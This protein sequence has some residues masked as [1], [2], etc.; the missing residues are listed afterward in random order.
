MRRAAKWIGIVVLV[1]LGLPVLAVAAALGLAN[2]DYG[3][4]LIERETASLTGGMVR[5]E[6][7]AGRF[8]DALRIGRIDVAD[9]KGV[10][11][12]V[13]GLALDWSPLKLLNSVVSV[14]QLAAKTIT[15]SRLPVSESKTTSSSGSFSLPVRIDLAKLEVDKA[16]IEAPVVGTRAELALNGSGQLRTLTEGTVHLDVKRLDQPGTYR[17]D[18]DVTSAGVTASVTAQEPP[19][20]LIATIGQLPDLGAVSIRADVKGPMD[21]LG[22]KVAISAGPLTADASGT[23]DTVHQAANLTLHAQAPAMQ[24][25]PDIGWQRVLVDAHV[26]G[27]FTR[28]DATGTIR[29]DA[30]SAPGTTIGAL[31][32]DVKGN[33]GHVELHATINDLHV[34]GPKPDLLSASPVVVD[35]AV[36]LDTPDRPATFHVAHK[37]IDLVG[38]AKLGTAQSVQA[39]LTLPDLAPLAQA[40][41]AD[42][43]GHAAL[44]LAATHDGDTSTASVKGIVAISGGMAPVPALIGDNGTIDLAAKMHGQDITLS[45]LAVTGKSVALGAKGTVT[46]QA[47]N[48]D[49]SASLKDLAAVQP[50]LAGSVDATGHAQGS[51]SDLAVH[52]DVTTNVTAQGYHSGQVVAHI[53]ATGLPSA[54]KAQVTAD[55]T[56]LDSPLSVALTAERAADGTLHADLSNLSWKSLQG[57]GTAAMAP[58]AKLPTGDLHLTFARLADLEPLL[59]RK[60]TGAADVKLNAD[61]QAA[62]LALRLSDVAVPGTA[63][64]QKLALDGTVTGLA[65]SPVIDATMTADGISASSV[66]GA[67]AQVTAK[68]PLTAI[69]TAITAQAPDVAGGPV[70]LA[71]NATVDAQNQA[72]A[73]AKLDA[74]WKDQ[75]L[76]LL[77][78]ARIAFADGVS[79]DRLRLGFR[80]A[81]LMVSGK[82]GSTLDLTASLRNLPAD[83]G[84]IVDPSLAADGTI[85]ADVRLTGTSSRPEGTVKL[86]AHRV[87]MRQGTGQ[88]L[89]P[90]NLDAN[91]TLQGTSALVDTR[92]TA[93]QT[94]VTVTG[95]APLSATGPLNLRT[96]AR[97]DL[98]MLD[99]ILTAEGRRARGVVTVNATVTGTATAPRA[100][101]TV[102]LRNGDVVDYTLGAHVS[103]LTA[104]IEADGD[105]IRLS[106]FS[107]KAGPGTLGG[108]GTISLA[109]AMPVDLHFT[110]NNARPLAS[111][112]LTALINA[113]LT[114]R[115]DV[116]GNLEAAG[117]LTVLHADIRIPDKL[118]PS[119]AVLPVRDANAPPPKPAPP[120]PPSSIGLNLTLSAPEQVFVRGRGLDAELGGTIHIRGTATDP[121][122][123][124]GLH[125]R[126]GTMSIIGTTLNFTKGT[127]SFTGAGISD[128]SILFVASSTTA[129]ITATLTVSGSAKNPKITLSSTP[130]M[131]QDEI[132]AQLLFGTSTSKLSP[133]QLAEIASALASLSGASG[134]FDPLNSVRNTLGLDR[135]SVGSGSSGNPTVE[136]G[137][138]VARGV[139]V[140]AKQGTSGGGPQATVQVDLAKGLKLEATAG[141]GQSTA[142][143]AGQGTDAASVGVTYQFEY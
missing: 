9:A 117:T 61:A 39:H 41:G 124:G 91:L 10:Y 18:A 74:A 107:G 3:R 28:P 8:P 34:P 85:A 46:Q 82:A 115:G 134:G 48:L 52:A 1:L 90:A 140:G 22:T 139:Y 92:L 57:G 29:L 120:A 24:P 126:H 11:V 66:H 97:L 99:P 89:P 4:H 136:A 125:L 102:A 71:T 49:W 114:V 141:S 33:Q 130:D 80:Q 70:R 88:A 17:A 42:V 36:T 54:P 138:Y 128:P 58:S 95:T 50:N 43:Q 87:H 20:G 59:G 81:E 123:D 67:T 63:A 30:L 83:V 15:V 112:L 68:G 142:T 21:A 103:D 35:A 133:F 64:L 16:T 5:I 69:E 13:T 98:A 93:G 62:R 2:I 27:P 113:D 37:L 79:I 131:P 137:R 108:S 109:G 26:Q 121:Q 73:L 101:G 44:D 135:L 86:T 53:D 129:T 25:A 47:I 106:R 23:V 76:R 127:V 100:N 32:A 7:L 118:P 77:A 132:L 111:D 45:N 105:T 19:K 94:R 40:G 119:I 116:K 31:T 65:N 96:N 84:A 51:P 6:G 78:P 12:S 122:P 72:V 14:D 75:T 38:T 60:L 55:G 56:L 104:L 143:G 110:A